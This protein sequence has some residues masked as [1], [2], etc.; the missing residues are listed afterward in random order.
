[1]KFLTVN[2]FLCVFNLS[3][4]GLIIGYFIAFSYAIYAIYIICYEFFS[5]SVV[6][7]QTKVLV[8]NS[9]QISPGVYIIEG[10]VEEKKTST[11]KF[12]NVIIN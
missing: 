8:K 4:G 9:E 11:S 5:E 10:I 1:M 12:L 7:K 6:T 2:K 3:L